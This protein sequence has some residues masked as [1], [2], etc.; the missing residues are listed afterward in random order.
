MM[1]ENVYKEKKVFLTG[2]TGFKGSWLLFWLHSLGA[3][4]KGYALAPE[5]DQDLYNAMLGDNICDS[6]IADIRDE[7]KLEKEIKDFQPDFIFHLAAQPLVRLSYKIPE[8]TFAVNVLGTAYVLRAVR[9]L[10]KKCVVVII[11]TDK[12][13]ENKEWIYPY[14]ETDRLGGLDPYSASKACAEILTGSYIHSFFPLKDI[15]L[16]KKA[17]VTARAGNVIGGGDWAKDRLIPDIV[18]A[19]SRNKTI[20][21]R[22]PASVRPWQHVLEPLSG[23]LRLGELVNNDPIKYYG[24]WNLGPLPSDH[25]TVE[26]FVREAISIWGTGKYTIVRQPDQLHEAGLLSLDISKSLKELDWCPKWTSAFAIKKTLQWYKA[27]QE[28]N[29]GDLMANDIKDYISWE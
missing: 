2:H 10:K 17:V 21:I 7:E 25:M 1:F 22:N 23:Y 14:R 9:K 29:A 6:V 15:S 11:T 19:I 28:S 18:R 13:Y 24:S 3:Q 27:N 8:E 26:E 16:H 20:E 12:V 5:N 4:V